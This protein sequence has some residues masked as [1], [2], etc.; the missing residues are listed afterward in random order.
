MNKHGN[1]QKANLKWK[2]YQWFLS[3]ELRMIKCWLMMRGNTIYQVSIRAL[4]RE[5]ETHITCN[6]TFKK[7]ENGEITKPKKITWMVLTGGLLI[8]LRW[9]LILFSFFSS[10][11]GLKVVSFLG[12]EKTRG[13]NRRIETNV[14]RI[15]VLEEEEEEEEAAMFVFCWCLG[16]YF[17]GLC[18]WNR[19]WSC[20]FPTRLRF[21]QQEN[22]N[23]ITNK[24]FLVLFRNF[25]IGKKM[26]QMHT[27]QKKPET[28]N[29]SKDKLF[30]SF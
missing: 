6:L 25:V 17:K 12:R 22:N 20:L 1:N 5:K 14:K 10:C 27:R 13:R 15:E 28:E 24:Q 30:L 21:H 26:Q 18:I 7:L 16:V 3:F 23:T 8:L 29:P 11:N 4:F 9:F 19:I 2:I